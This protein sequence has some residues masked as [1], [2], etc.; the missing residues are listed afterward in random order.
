MPLRLIKRPDSALWWI[1][2]TV[3]GQRI[4]EST[5]TDSAEQAEEA[6]AV[7]EAAAFRE[8]IHG[9][10]R[11]ST[12]FAAACLR[13]YPRSIYSLTKPSEHH[14]NGRPSQE[15]PCGTVQTFPIL[16][17]P[18]AA[19]EPGDG[20]FN[21]PSPGQDKEALR[22]IRSL[23]DLEID[24]AHHPTQAIAKLWPLIAA[25]GVELGQEWIKPEQSG[26]DQHTT[27]AIL[28]IGRVNNRVK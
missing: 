13:V 27:V 23:D 18:S 11:G 12:T 17:Q 2:G 1:V 20:A 21:D 4:R 5:G 10:P 25:V 3:R 6:R 24:A 19:I 15:C 28:N 22:L 26:H 16:R 7:R 9:A 14:P 8:A